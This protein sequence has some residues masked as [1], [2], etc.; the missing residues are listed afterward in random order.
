[1][2]SVIAV[3][4]VNKLNRL[5]DFNLPLE[6]CHIYVDCAQLAAKV[7]SS[8]DATGPLPKAPLNLTPIASPAEEV[9]IVGMA[10]RLPGNINTPEEFWSALV[11]QREDIMSAI[12]NDR[13]DHESF[14]R[15]TWEK[16][17]DITLQKAGFI[18]LDEFDNAFF[19]ISA[20]EAAVTSPFNRLVLET[21]FDALENAAIPPSSLK[22]S[23]TGVFVASGVEDG[24]SKLLLK[25]KLYDCE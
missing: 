10:C 4:I 5:F 24:Y 6:T 7:A 15:P 13:W 23:N 8:L 2:T 22:G 16:P 9:V 18:K 12:P 1:M 14:Y 17:G 19:G 11:D 25:A 21:A 20:A 3:A